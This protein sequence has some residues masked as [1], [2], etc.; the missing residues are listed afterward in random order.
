MVLCPGLQFFPSRGFVRIITG[1]TES[2]PLK[3]CVSIFFYPEAGKSCFGLPGNFETAIFSTY[4]R[5]H[6]R[7]DKRTFIRTAGLGAAGTLMGVQACSR[8]VK[9]KHKVPPGSWVWYSF[10]K[11]EPESVLQ[12]MKRME[13]LGFQ[14]VH[15]QAS[16]EQLETIL[17]RLPGTSLRIH[18]WIVT[19]MV[20]NPDLIRDHPDWYAVSRD[21]KSS[22]THPPYVPYYKW[23]CPSK[24]EVIEYTL[25][26]VD[27]YCHLD[28]L[29]GMHLDYI[30]F[31]DV[32]LPVGL[33][34]K[35]NLVQDREY[36]EFDFCYC[37]TCRESFKKRTGRDPLEESDPAGDVEWRQFRFDAITNVVN[38]IYD[39]V[40]DRGKRL[41]AA[42]FPTPEI[43]RKLVRQEWSK[44]NLDQIHPMIYHNFYEKKPEWI[45][46]ATKEGV[47]ALRGKFPLYS[48]VFV[49]ALK[50]SDMERL[51]G[52]GQR[53]GAAGI[54]LF[55]WNSMTEEHWK[56]FYL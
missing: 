42:V 39:W 51:Y 6:K 19:M 28:G 1:I 47:E 38:Q 36:P 23:L 2:L 34:E 52:M 40:H 18:A 15:I 14:G 54:T 7:M 4:F 30:R 35:Y 3:G 20:G 46:T 10:G 49:P 27:K 29:E 25:N 56:S 21:G 24:P 44:W 8:W 26:R 16:P 50:P 55:N 41:S 32:I 9:Q 48:G 33:W 22:A 5:K 45:E 43:A 37:Q 17:P 13:A 11:K 12:D 31:P 53:A